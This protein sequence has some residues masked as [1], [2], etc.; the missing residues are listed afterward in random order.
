MYCITILYSPSLV[1]GLFVR[2]WISHY[3]CS[4]GLVFC[5]SLCLIA[6]YS[7]SFLSL[8]L[9]ICERVDRQSRELIPVLAAESNA[10]KEILPINRPHTSLLD[11][12]QSFWM[13]CGRDSLVVAL[14]YL[15]EILRMDGPAI[16]RS[17]T[18]KNYS[19]VNQSMNALWIS[20]F[21]FIKS[22]G[23]VNFSHVCVLYYC[24]PW[25]LFV[26]P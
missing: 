14:H 6:L 23:A 5:T 25:L 24:S 12:S 2:L 17:I 16:C 4:W 11:R 19:H 21:E 20:G 3:V 26:S 15:S 18:S 13:W 10:K 8:F 9:E 7:H 1:L 22:V